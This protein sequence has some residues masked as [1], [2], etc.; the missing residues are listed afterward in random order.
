MSHTTNLKYIYLGRL[1]YAS[2][3][4]ALGKLRQE[5]CEFENSLDYIVRICHKQP[6]SSNT[7]HIIE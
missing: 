5:A 2:V 6:I 4:L 3:V 7:K 1:A